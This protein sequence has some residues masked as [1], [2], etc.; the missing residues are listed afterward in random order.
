MTAIDWRLAT[1]AH[2]S[3]RQRETNPL[4]I[5]LLVSTVSPF[6]LVCTRLRALLWRL[7]IEHPWFYVLS[8]PPDI[9]FLSRVRLR[10]RWQARRWDF[11]SRV[12]P[13]YWSTLSVLP[14]DTKDDCLALAQNVLRTRTE[15]VG[16]QS[17]LSWLRDRGLPY[18]S[19][20]SLPFFYQE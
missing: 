10:C 5:T 1:R 7:E 19:I 3:S 6:L 18:A 8:S 14:Y 9:S 4:P 12:R 2:F 11:H 13:A 15:V 20:Q 17:C 16:R